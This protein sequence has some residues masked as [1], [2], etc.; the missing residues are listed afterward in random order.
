MKIAF[1]GKGGVG[2][3][4]L[5]AWMADY[6][7]R[8][9]EDVYLVDADTA[10]SLG[11]ACGLGP[12]ALPPPLAARERL[13][14]ERIGE[15]AFLALTPEVGDLPEALGV[16]V[17]VGLGPRYAATVGRKRL[18]VMGGVVSGG[19]GCACAA[20]T[21]LRAVLRHVL[22]AMPGHVLVD[23]EAGVEHLGRG[24]AGD[25]DALVVVSEES[26]RSLDVAAR[27]SAMGREIGLARQALAL[28]RGVSS[29]AATALAARPGLPEDVTR[30][31]LV[32]ELTARQAED[33]SVLS[34]NAVA[35][36][37]AACAALLARLE[38]ER[39]AA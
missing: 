37:D 25:L 14:R 34:L 6:L 31:P 15:G 2:K 3:T 36:A 13:V 17:P 11:A 27:V 28:T 9:G 10:G 35:V 33:G 7:A 16:D 20:G 12:E 19:S 1:A 18:L 23:F 22:G 5:A 32:A 26:R 30:V 29:V 21:L 4:T 38:R 39:S 8:R 24:T